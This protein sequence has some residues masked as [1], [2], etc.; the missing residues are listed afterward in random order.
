[1]ATLELLAIRSMAGVV[2]Q[3]AQPSGLHCSHERLSAEDGDHTLQIVGQ[4]VEA[5]DV[6]AESLRQGR[7]GQRA[8]CTM[9]IWQLRST[10][11]QALLLSA[12]YWI[13]AWMSLRIGTMPAVARGS[14]RISRGQSP[15][16]Q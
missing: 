4:D 9:G 6:E 8:F 16:C 1:M 10:T 3:M 13:M 7:V 12:R 5:E 2:R 11:P 15:R 14:D